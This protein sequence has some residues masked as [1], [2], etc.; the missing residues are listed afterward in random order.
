MI[1]RFPDNKGLTLAY[2]ELLDIGIA[3]SNIVATFNES[4]PLPQPPAVARIV[5]SASSLLVHCSQSASRSRLPRWSGNRSSGLARFRKH[6]G[7][8]EVKSRDHA[9]EIIHIAVHH[10]GEMVA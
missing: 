4:A 6:G 9:A 7:T 5:S 3:Q 8:L 1:F 10:Y 2:A